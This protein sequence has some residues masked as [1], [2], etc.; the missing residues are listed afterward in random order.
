[1][2]A[3]FETLPD[4]VNHIGS[5]ILTAKKRSVQVRMRN[6]GYYKLTQ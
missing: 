6:V 4:G 2:E 5:A 1:M 3:T